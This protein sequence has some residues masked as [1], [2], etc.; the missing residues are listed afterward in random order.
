MAAPDIE[1]ELYRLSIAEAEL[2][3]SIALLICHQ[4]W[5]CGIVLTVAFRPGAK[6]L[7]NGV[8]IVRI[9]PCVIVAPNLCLRCDQ[10]RVESGRAD[11][12]DT[13]AVAAI[14]EV[15]ES[16]EDVVKRYW[17]AGQ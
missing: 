8:R 1:A 14:I 6:E 3:C 12:L 17:L 5:V 13:I 4:Q 2:D 9:R 16:N 15:E 7:K 10:I 11:A